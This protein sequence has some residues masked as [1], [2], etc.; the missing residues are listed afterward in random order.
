MQRGLMQLYEKGIQ[1]DPKS[2]YIVINDCHC[3][4]ICIECEHMHR[5]PTTFRKYPFARC[6]ILEYIFDLG[7]EYVC[8]YGHKFKA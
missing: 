6:S 2:Y 7:D 4:L 8:D 3:N 1:P 5:R